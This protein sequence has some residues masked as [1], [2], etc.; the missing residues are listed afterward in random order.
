MISN[1]TVCPEVEGGGVQIWLGIQTRITAQH[2]NRIDDGHHLS[3][4]ESAIL[5][6]ESGDSESCD[7]NR[8]IPRSL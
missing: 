8:A 7:S 5:N 2:G 1:S 3:G 6:R 4:T